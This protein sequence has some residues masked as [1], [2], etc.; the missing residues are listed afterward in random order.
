MNSLLAASAEA[1]NGNAFFGFLILFG[2]GWLIWK[3]VNSGGNSYDVDITRR[4]SG[5]I[6][7]RR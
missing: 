5:T 1:S 4:T 7:K 6:K 2:I 3:L